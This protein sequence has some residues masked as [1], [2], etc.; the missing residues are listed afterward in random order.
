MPQ[1]AEPDRSQ[2]KNVINLMD[3]IET[4]YCGGRWNR[5]K[6]AT[7]SEPQGARE[8][9]GAQTWEGNSKGRIEVASEVRR[10]GIAP[11]V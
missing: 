10:L 9:T 1:K 8:E 2:Q 6:E 5:R 3:A 4:Q 11:L 7:G